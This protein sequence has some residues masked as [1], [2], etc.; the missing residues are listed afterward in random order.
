MKTASLTGLCLGVLAAAH[1]VAAQSLEASPAV[2]VWESDGQARDDQSR[3][4]VEAQRARAE[5]D[6]A[7][8]RELRDYEQAQRAIE[9]DEWT[10]AVAQFQAIAAP[11]LRTSA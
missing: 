6:R 10:A 8:E 7:R 3:A 5:L 11:K 9:R 4:E 2:W 1:P